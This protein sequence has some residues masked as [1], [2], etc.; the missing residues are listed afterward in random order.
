MAIIVFL[1]NEEKTTHYYDPWGMKSITIPPVIE[2][3]PKKVNYMTISLSTGTPILEIFTGNP[4]LPLRALATPEN[5]NRLFRVQK[6][7]SLC[8][9]SEQEVMVNP[10]RIIK[11]S[12]RG[13][14]LQRRNAIGLFFPDDRFLLVKNTEKNLLAIKEAKSHE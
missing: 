13:K 7:I 12:V 4:H 6:F 11:Y 2:V 8:D 10:D 1:L 3:E 5:I 14:V 9:R